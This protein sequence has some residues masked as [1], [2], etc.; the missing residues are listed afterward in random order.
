MKTVISHNQ[1]ETHKL[2]AELAHR[3]KTSGGVVALHGDLGA[4]KTAFVQGFAQSLGITER[5]TSP[6]FILIRQYQIPENDKMLYHLDLYRLEQP[7]EFNELGLKD[8]LNSF[9]IILIEWAEKAVNLLPVNTIHITIKKISDNE[10]EI[11]ID[12]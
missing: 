3:L 8:L 1:D 12:S 7:H 6:T 4:G 5:V 11:T 10:R 9:D 2:A